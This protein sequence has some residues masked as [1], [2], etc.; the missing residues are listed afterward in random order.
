MASR[1]ASAVVVTALLALPAAAAGTAFTGPW[2]PS[3]EAAAEAA[4]AR[5]G[6]KR[7]LDLRP[8]ILNVQGVQT[9]VLGG[10][11][12]VVATVSDLRRAMQ[13]L[14]AR[15]SDLEVRVELPADVLFDFDK[16][17]I[18]PDAARALAQLATVIR[19]YPKGHASLEGH[20]DGKG[21][22]AYNQSLSE[23]RAAAVKRWL[24]EKEAIAGDRLATRGWGKSRPVA[25]NADEAGRQ[26][27]RRVE[28]IIQKQ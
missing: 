13:D 1:V 20:T 15:E 14:G 8:S 11:K 21:N 25:S 12:Q 26:K 3:A 16:A 9:A 22:D 6:V 19:A 5:L 23:R 18:R 7:A 4:A 17:D 10:G 27:N 24:V 28:A 2:D